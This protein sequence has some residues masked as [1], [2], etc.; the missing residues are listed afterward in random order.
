MAKLSSD[1][2]ESVLFSSSGSLV[3]ACVYLCEREEAQAASCWV[4]KSVFL[5]RV[6][7]PGH[8]VI[9]WKAAWPAVWSRR[10]G[11]KGHFQSFLWNAWFL[12]HLSAVCMV[13]VSYFHGRHLGRLRFLSR[14]LLFPCMLS[15]EGK[16]HLC[17][18]KS[19]QKT[20]HWLLWKGVLKKDR[21]HIPL[22]LK[23]RYFHFHST[24]NWLP[25]P[26][27]CT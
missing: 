25:Q 12:E 10:P 20:W 4:T 1:W 18:W 27:K 8:V 5:T 2:S 24:W 11:N 3:H 9:I 22:I 14:V 6:P 7:L 16:V 17:L 26:P 13:Y 19:K 23:Q 15:C 21:Y